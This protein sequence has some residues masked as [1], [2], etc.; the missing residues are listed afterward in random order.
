MK[1]QMHEHDYE[2]VLLCECGSQKPEME[3][4]VPMDLN[5]LVDRSYENGEWSVFMSNLGLQA[6][7]K[8]IDDALG[9]LVKALREY[10]DEY[11]EDLERNM[12][13][14][15][16]QY[17]YHSLKRFKFSASY[18]KQLAQITLLF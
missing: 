1:D 17:H 15:K 12:N 10:A 2:A 18:E 16:R 8:T 3:L 6:T 13:D 5:F 4:P 9:L 14:P 11:F 7:G